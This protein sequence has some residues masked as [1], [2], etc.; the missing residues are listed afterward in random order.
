MNLSASVG[1]ASVGYDTEVVLAVITV[2]ILRKD[3]GHKKV[4]L[5]SGV[6]ISLICTITAKTLGLKGRDVSI[7]IKEVGSEEEV[8]VA[9]CIE[10]LSRR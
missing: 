1:V 9:K 4:L 6:Q 2:E 10:Y 3:Y 8:L 5:D 7:T